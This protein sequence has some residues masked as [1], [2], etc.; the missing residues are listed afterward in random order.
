M[1]I[2]VHCI[3]EANL[4]LRV[5][6]L[7]QA[8]KGA[9]LF[10]FHEHLKTIT[11]V[12]ITENQPYKT[13]KGFFDNFSEPEQ[14]IFRITASASINFLIDIESRLSNGIS[15]EDILILELVS[16]QAGQT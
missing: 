11:S 10:E 8:F 9:L 2:N 12:T 16:D 5:Y 7:F 4:Q 14:D 3:I 1:F 15:K 13:A 6:N